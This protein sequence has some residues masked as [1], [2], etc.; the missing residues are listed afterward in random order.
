MN[1][2]ELKKQTLGITKEKRLSTFFVALITA[3]VFFVPFI[4]MNEGYFL[5]Y[6]DFNVQQIPFYKH[7]HEMLRSGNFA[8]DW[9]TDLGVNFIGSYSFYTIGSPFFWLTLPFPTDWVPYFIGPLL[10]LKFACSALSGYLYIRR[11]TRTPEAARI[12]GLLYAFS[13]FAVYNIFFNHFHEAIVF[14]PLLLLSVELL[15]T[16]NRRGFFAAMVAITAI[17]NYFFFFC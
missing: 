8:W 4:V 13:G 9:G 1:F 16:E 7:C 3:A 14:F 11:F 5:F 10:I 2:S 17:S 12:G 6:G 15:I